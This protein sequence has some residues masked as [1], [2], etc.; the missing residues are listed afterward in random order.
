MLQEGGVLEAMLRGQ[1]RPMALVH[2]CGESHGL[3][4][5]A[6]FK[7]KTGGEDARASL[8]EGCKK[9]LRKLV[10]RL[11]AVYDSL[12]RTEQAEVGAQASAVEDALV[13]VNGSTVCCLPPDEREA[14]LKVS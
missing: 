8:E 12:N 4:S 6:V 3:M 1:G 14:V 5:N 9:S 13:A 11:G 2:T 7:S 10:E